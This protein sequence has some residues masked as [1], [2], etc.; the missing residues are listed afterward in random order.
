MAGYKTGY[1]DAIA[2]AV[3]IIETEDELPGE[4]SAEVVAAMA[5]VGPIDNARAAVRA[6]KKSALKRLTLLLKE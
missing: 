5:R 2:D 4:P 1:A 3:R 6:T